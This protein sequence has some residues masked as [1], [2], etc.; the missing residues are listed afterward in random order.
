MDLSGALPQSGLHPHAPQKKSP[1]QIFVPDQLKRPG[2]LLFD[3]IIL[4]LL[5]DGHELHLLRQATVC[6]VLRRVFSACTKNDFTSVI[7]SD[8][9]SDLKIDVT[10][11]SIHLH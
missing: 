1:I 8:F 9:H 10:L 4:C 3:F 2:Y 11:K 7:F 6:S 5:A